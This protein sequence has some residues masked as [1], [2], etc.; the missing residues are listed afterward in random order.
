M[1]K[2]QHD[3]Q[4]SEIKPVLNWVDFSLFVGG[5]IILYIILIFGT[6]WLA[7]KLPNEKVLIYINGFLTQLSFIVLV[8]ILKRIRQWSWQDIGWRSV[9]F[10]KQWALILRLYLLTLIINMIYTLYLYQRGYTPPSTDVYT[11]LLGETTWLTYLLNLLLAVVLAPLV[12][13]TLFRGIIF[14]SL[15]TY[16]GKWTAAAISAALFSALHLQVYGFFP[17]FILGLVLAHLYERNRS[18]YPS[19]AF[20]A[21]NNLV[22]MTLIAGI[23]P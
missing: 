4:L 8:F 3:P 10:K 9:N 2:K 7:G 5:I 6:I 19:M 15:R 22:A 16:F 12:E 17:R 23:A 18:L 11:K 1:E 20:H 13:E 21:L 14:G